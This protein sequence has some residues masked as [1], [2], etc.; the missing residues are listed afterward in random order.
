MTEKDDEEADRFSDRFDYCA[1]AGCDEGARW[2]CNYCGEHFCAK[3][4]EKHIKRDCR[5]VRGTIRKPKKV[6]PK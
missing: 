5:H 6:N 3:C 4:S 2:V 1:C